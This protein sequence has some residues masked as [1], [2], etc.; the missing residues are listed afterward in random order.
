MVEIRWGL[1][2]E[3][4]GKKRFSSP[5]KKKII[6]KE[7]LWDVEKHEGERRGITSSLRFLSSYY[8]K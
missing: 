8:P 6:E 7:K 5:L 3:G 1:E 2:I 4:Q